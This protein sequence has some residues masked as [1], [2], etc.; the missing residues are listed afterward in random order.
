MGGMKQYLE[1]NP[2]YIEIVE[3]IIE[4]EEENKNPDNPWIRDKD[5]DSCWESS[6]VNEHPTRLYQLEVNG[7]LERVADTNSTTKY[8]LQS[9]E[10]AKKVIDDLSIDKEGNMEVM[11]DFPEEDELPDDLFDDV[12]GY[13][14]VKWLI[15]RGL[16]TDDITNFLLVGPP[17]SAKTVFLMCIEKMGGAEF[18]PSNDA[19]AAGFNQ[20]MFEK[21]PQY[22]LLDELDDM[23]P[24]DQKVLSQY[25]ETGIVKETKH[26]KTREMKTNTKTF[27]S[28]NGTDSILDHIVDR[29][30]TLHFEEYDRDEYIEVCEHILQRNEGKTKENA[31]KIAEVLWEKEESGDV[32]QAIQVARLSR[33]D[34]EKVVEVIDEYS[35]PQEERFTL[36]M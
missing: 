26:D 20:V 18:I 19:T 12:I 33:G 11:H 32:R 24:S 35:E 6:D 22:I 17:G 5:Y 31:R 4:Y 14:D 34:P 27:A 3:N 29:F 23:D 2:D 9:R 30:T 16:T 7:V 25:T 8:S 13:D 21:T 28:A 36:G 10:R 1:N 15:R